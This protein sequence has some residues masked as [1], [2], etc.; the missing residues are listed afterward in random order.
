M[1]RPTLSPCM[2]FKRLVLGRMPS[3]SNVL[4]SSPSAEIWRRH[5]QLASVLNIAIGPTDND[6]YS[7]SRVNR[8]N[9]LQSDD[10]HISSN[11][12]MRLAPFAL[13]SINAVGVEYRFAPR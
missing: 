11:N 1:R 13:A 4:L 8:V 9:A 6:Q 10:I 7:T 5:S 12:F 3:L 2:G